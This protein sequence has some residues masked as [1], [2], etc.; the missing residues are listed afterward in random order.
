MLEREKVVMMSGG[1][2]FRD[3]G[4]HRPWRAAARHPTDCFRKHDRLCRQVHLRHWDLLRESV[5]LE[6][7]L[8]LRED[9]SSVTMSF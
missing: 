4:P 1:G 5:C 9:F 3:I 2:D 6:T 8:F 7:G